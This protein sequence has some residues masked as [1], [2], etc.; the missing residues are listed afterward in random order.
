[1]STPTLEEVFSPGLVGHN[2]YGSTD[3]T[4][5]A[6]LKDIT[7]SDHFSTATWCLPS[8]RTARSVASAQH[9][10]SESDMSRIRRVILNLSG[11]KLEEHSETA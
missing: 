10:E 6:P 1:M 4:D 9:C 7:P 8:G 3:A 11:R 2:D 5:F